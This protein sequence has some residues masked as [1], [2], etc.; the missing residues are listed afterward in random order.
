[1]GGFI[2]WLH[3]NAGTE[4]LLS[5]RSTPLDS[6]LPEEQDPSV[7]VTAEPNTSIWGQRGCCVL[8]SPPRQIQDLQIL[9]PGLPFRL[10]LSIVSFETQRLLILMK[11]NFIILLSLPLLLM[12]YP[13]NG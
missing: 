4:G 5:E 1:M 6:A 13:R 9:S 11:S 12:S 10:T 2:E 8:L 3:V 7:V